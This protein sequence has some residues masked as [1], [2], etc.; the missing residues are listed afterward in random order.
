[1]N[2]MKQSQILVLL[3]TAAEI[4]NVKESKCYIIKMEL[5]NLK[6]ILLMEFPRNML[7]SIMKMEI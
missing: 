6:D 4:K 5:D 2:T 7:N 1:M 3:A